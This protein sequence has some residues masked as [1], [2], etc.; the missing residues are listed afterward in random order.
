MKINVPKDILLEKLNLSSHFVSNRLTSSTVLQGVLIKSDT[1]AIHLYSTNLT[2]YYHTIIAEKTDAFEIIVEPKK[3]IEFLNLLNPGVIDIEVKEKEL[4][5]SQEKTKGSFPLMTKE[6][7]PVPPSITEPAEKLESSFFLKQMPLVLFAAS[8]DET[9]PSLTGINFV[10]QE[11]ELL[12]VS[13]DG[14]RLSFIKS[15]RK[16]ELPSMI[17]PAEFLE[18]VMRNVKEKEEVLFSYSKAEKMVKFV[19]SDNDFYSRL[20]EGEFPPF[21]KVIPAETKT[22]VT[23]DK[24]E[25]LRNVKLISVFARDFSNVVICEFKKEGMSI[26]PKKEANEENTAFQEVEFEGEDQ[27]VAFNF[28]FLLDL[29]NHIDGKSVIVEILRSD[30]P[31]MFKL[32]ENKNFLHIIMPVRIQE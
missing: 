2:T 16:E 25:F 15:K 24:T 26:R 10:Q 13:T 30:A 14:F 23:I 6:E 1:K 18:E 28:R 7:F 21:E 20:I 19:V 31:V 27:K 29:L 5:I 11:E 12:M 32:P 3:I 4:V 22:K 8:S 9:R 17:V